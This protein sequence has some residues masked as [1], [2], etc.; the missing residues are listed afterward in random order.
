MDPTS[1]KMK[2]DSK[3]VHVGSLFVRIIKANRIW[4]I[5]FSKHLF[6]LMEDIPNADDQKQP[7]FIQVRH[8]LT[9]NS[10]DITW[11]RPPW[12]YS[13]S[14]IWPKIVTVKLHHIF[15]KKN[16]TYIQFF[17]EKNR[18]TLT[19]TLSRAHTFVE[20]TEFLFK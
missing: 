20:T 15:L 12:G 10:G 2:L 7:G 5:K 4:R 11:P 1:I 6:G 17:L 16:N 18:C 8:E 9:I 19:P 14:C 13:S 3:P